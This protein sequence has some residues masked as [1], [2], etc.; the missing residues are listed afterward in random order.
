LVARIYPPAQVKNSLNY[1]ENK[2]RL[3]K[4]ECLYA[5]NFLL[6]KD[7]MN[8]YQ[9]LGIFE[10]RSA[11]NQRTSN[12]G[13]HISLNFDPSERIAGEKLIQ[14]ASEYLERIGFGEQPH[15]VYEHHDAGH[16]HLH[17]VTTLIKE[18]G[19]RIDIHN[20]GRNASEKARK[21]IEIAYN[22]VKASGKRQSAIHT[23]DQVNIQRVQ[24]GKSETKS[25]ITNVLDEVIPKFKYT[26]LAELNAILKQYNV[27]AD[28]GP[29]GGRIFKNR[30]LLYK[31]LD[32]K[33]NKTG[34]QIK[35]SSIN[36]TPTL[37]NLEKRF[38]ENK[39]NREPERKKLKTAIEWALTKGPK[40][41]DELI[42]RLKKDGIQTVLRQNKDGLVYGIT[43]IDFRTKSVFNGSDLGKSYSAANLL[44]RLEGSPVNTK[45]ARGIG[46]FHGESRTPD[47]SKQTK[48]ELGNITSLDKSVHK[49]D[50]LHLLLKS[51]KNENRLPYQ[52]LQK[53]RKK[54]RRPDL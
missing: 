8:F 15:L 52:L 21:E 24:Y 32:E 46:P 49:D 28:R 51:E 44:R 20:L 9:K 37:T 43:F 54:K 53:K 22:L 26:S 50:L 45:A 30:G 36:S 38:S 10:N 39:E 47:L 48:A 23:L 18:D 13:L 12:A 14:I 42:H 40:S 34:V 29:E 16:P 3:G 31:I 2:V 33:G 19:K 5:G 1:N 4:A 17:I 11:L 27:I 7:Q 35:A 41:L 6:E 25:S